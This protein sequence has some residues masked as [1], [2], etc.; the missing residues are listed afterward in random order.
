MADDKGNLSPA[1]KRDADD[2]AFRELSMRSLEFYASADTLEALP[3]AALEFAQRFYGDEQIQVQQIE[4]VEL[5]DVSTSPY[6]E[7]YKVR[8]QFIAVPTGIKRSDVLRANEEMAQRLVER[9]WY[10]EA[11][12]CRQVLYD[13]LVAARGEHGNPVVLDAVDAWLTEREA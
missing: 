13:M 2:K 8:A 4:R 6:K 12:D 9:I 1:E 10:L 5:R 3:D 7:K 11:D